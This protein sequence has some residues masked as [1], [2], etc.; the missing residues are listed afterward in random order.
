MFRIL[1]ISSN[2]RGVPSGLVVPL[3]ITFK[4]YSICNNFGE[5]FNA[6]VAAGSYVDPAGFVVMLHQVDTRPSEIV[7]VKEFAAG[8]RCPN[9][10]LQ[11]IWQLLLRGSGG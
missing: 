2:L 7:N 9:I 5:V 11:A 4:A 1:L 10:E 8:F 6:H 3:N